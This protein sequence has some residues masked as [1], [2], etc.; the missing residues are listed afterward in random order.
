MV[1]QNQFWKFWLAS[2]LQ[3]ILKRCHK[4]VDFNVKQMEVIINTNIGNMIR[5]Q[6]WNHLLDFELLLF[7]IGSLKNTYRSHPDGP[8][9][10]SPSKICVTQ[11]KAKV[12]FRFKTPNESIKATRKSSL[13]DGIKEVAEIKETMKSAREGVKSSLR[14]E[15][16]AARLL[17][18]TSSN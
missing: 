7:R 2:R 15:T 9:R 10:L 18:G 14:Q 4:N 16:R 13:N 12:L 11:I 6:V 8:D 1:I 3:Q 17:F 5:K